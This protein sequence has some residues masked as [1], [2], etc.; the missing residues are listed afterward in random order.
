[1]QRERTCKAGLTSVIVVFVLVLGA[2]Q[3]AAGDYDDKDLS[4]RLASGF[5]RF[6][7]VSAF[8]GETA[9]NRWSPAVNPASADWT[10]VPGRCGV[11]LA[12]YYSHMSFDA[13]MELNLSGE[14]GAWDTRRW[15]TF[16][17]TLSQL[18]SNNVLDRTGLEFDYETDTFQLQWGKRHGNWALGATLNYNESRVTQRAAGLEVRHTEA[19][20]WRVRVGGLYEPCCKWLVGLVAEYGWSPFDFR[21]VVPTRGGLLQ[22]SG[23][24]T[25]TQHILRAGI[26]Y[27]YMPLSTTFFDYQFA[28]F[29]NDQGVLET[30]RFQAGVQHNIAKPLWLRAGATTDQFGNVGGMAGLSIAWAEWGQLHVGYQRG[31]LPELL[32]TFGES[33]VFQFTL[34]LNF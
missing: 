9:A 1:M 11:V 6:T 8:G 29:E 26:S 33:D 22:V 21:A 20:T 25:L 3:A 32:P 5:I 15:G 24:D 23:E 12:P 17:P 18:R 14:A 34:S 27:E 7:E 16:V 19:E 10:K 28:R 30:H 4:L 31:V 13:G 2:P